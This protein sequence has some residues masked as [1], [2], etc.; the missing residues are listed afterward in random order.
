MRLRHSPCSAI[1]LFVALLVPVTG[2]AQVAGGVIA[3][4]VTDSSGAVLPKAQVV[5][6]NLGTGI[7]T[8]LVANDAGVYRA[9]NLLPGRHEITASSPGFASVVRQ[10]VVLTVGASLTADLQLKTRPLPP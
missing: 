6:R 4:T 7:A 1:F 5:I 3:G 8:E 9:P 10:D 2:Y